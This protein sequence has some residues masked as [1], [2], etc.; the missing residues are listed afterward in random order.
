MWKFL[1]GFSLLLVLDI[2]WL[3]VIE[4]FKIEMFEVQNRT[5]LGTKDP[6][7]CHIKQKSTEYYKYF[8]NMH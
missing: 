1:R 3:A 6:Y 5:L 4:T 8:S 2:S 7:F